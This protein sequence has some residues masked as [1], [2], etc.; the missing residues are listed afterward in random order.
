MILYGGSG[1]A[2]VIR[3]CVRSR[4][5]EVTSIFDDNPAITAL[6]ETPVVCP[7]NPE[8]DTN[9]EVIISIG[10]NLIR[11]RISERVKHSFGKAIHT[12]V[13][14]SPYSKVDIGTVVMQGSIINAG[15]SI[16]KHC[17]INT[18]TVIEHDCVIHDFVHISPNV[19]LCGSVEV[20]EGTHVGASAVVIPNVK[21]GK[22]CVIGA[23]TV[24]TDHVP[25]FSLIVGVPG[26]V[27]RNL[28]KTV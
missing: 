20:G 21:I 15:A 12:S 25:D 7:Y 11:K 13:I 17:I 4:G 28:S 9:E 16:G 26:K 22:W 6:D 10:D 2:K 8:L 14:Q 19:T 27:V 23:G 24:V 18:A 1:H 5:E 3:D